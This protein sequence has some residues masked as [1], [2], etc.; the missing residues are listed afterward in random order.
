MSKK[1]FTVGS[2]ENAFNKK[3]VTIIEEATKTSTAEK[4]P[5]SLYNPGLADILGG[6]HGWMVLLENKYAATLARK[7]PETVVVGEGCSNKDKRWTVKQKRKLVA[8][9]RAT[10][11]LHVGGLVAVRGIEKNLDLVLA[12]NVDFI[13]TNGLTAADIREIWREYPGQQFFHID[14]Y[15]LGDPVLDWAQPVD[16]VIELIES[17]G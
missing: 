3:I 5:G 15:C 10:H 8:F 11:S 1:L 6:L 2:D 14:E 12:V 17:L 16:D 7:K 9:H 4:L 13:T